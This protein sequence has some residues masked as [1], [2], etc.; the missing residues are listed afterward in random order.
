LKA[1]ERG[2]PGRK[3]C[4]GGNEEWRNIDLVKLICEELDRISPLGGDRSHASAI[5]FVKDR[6]GHD[7]RYAI[8]DRLAI[9]ELGYSHAHTFREGLPATVRWYV[10]NQ[11]WCHRVLGKGKSE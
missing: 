1:L 11:E 3:Y 9:R 4:F 10:E 5:A 7:W 6:A 8:D 2:K